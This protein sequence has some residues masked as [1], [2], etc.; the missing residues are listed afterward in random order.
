M[1]NEVI[2]VAGGSTGI[3]LA[4]A[5]YLSAKYIVVTTWRKTMPSP[6][7]VAEIGGH[8]LQCDVGKYEDCVRLVEEAEKLG[9]VVGLV[10]SAAV[11]PEPVESVSDMDISLWEM[12]IHNNLTGTFYMSKAII[13]A[14]R[15]AG[16]GA[17]VLVSSTAGRKG[18]STAGGR[19]G[20]AKVPYATSKAGIIA[21]T[22]G[23]A[24][25][26]ACENIRVN[27]MAPGPV[28]TRMLTNPAVA[29]NIPLRRIGSP[30]ECAKAIAFLLED[31]T[32]TTGCTL[33]L[34]GGLYMN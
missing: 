6:E 10:H 7:D 28:E 8:S 3:G 18:A 21:F 13:P 26:L 9:P 20:K 24:T 11:N 34:C 27:C 15:R 19:P 5:K 14:L 23:L 25:E 2:I 17:I 33:D 22:K 1:K 31:A 30:E 29:A 16:K 4:T 32:F 12:V